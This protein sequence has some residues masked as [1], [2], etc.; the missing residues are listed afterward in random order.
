M[1][2]GEEQLLRE[3]NINAGL[4]RLFCVKGT[5]ETFALHGSN[6]GSCRALAT[7]VPPILLLWSAVS[8]NRQFGKTTICVIAGCNQFIVAYVPQGDFAEGGAFI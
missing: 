5:F 4:W 2:L 1:S 7:Q 8:A 3:A 6:I